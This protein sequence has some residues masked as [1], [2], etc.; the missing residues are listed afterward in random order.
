[1]YYMADDF[2][3]WIEPNCKKVNSTSDKNGDS[4]HFSI[5]LLIWHITYYV[6]LPLCAS[7]CA[8]C[9]LFDC[10]RSNRF[11]FHRKNRFRHLTQRTVSKIYKVCN[12]NT[13]CTCVSV[14]TRAKWAAL[15][16]VFHHCSGLAHSHH[17]VSHSARIQLSNLTIYHLNF[18][19]Y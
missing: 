6:S 8:F 16:F 4:A 17:S 15:N 10:S 1:M 14:F 9:L 18:A 13:L 7:H 3:H 5:S 2:A 11:A 12:W 19:Y